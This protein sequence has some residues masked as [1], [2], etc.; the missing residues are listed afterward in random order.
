MDLGKVFG[1]VQRFDN[2]AKVKDHAVEVLSL[3]E[4]FDKSQ[5]KVKSFNER[6]ALF[7]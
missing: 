2:Y 3:S 6:E 4:R 7:K 1:T 5:E